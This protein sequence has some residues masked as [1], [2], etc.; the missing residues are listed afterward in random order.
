MT[1]SATTH[2]I[3]AFS[4]F[5][6]CKKRADKVQLFGKESLDEEGNVIPFIEQA[7]FITHYLQLPPLRSCRKNQRKL[8]IFTFKVFL[9]K[10]TWFL[11]VLKMEIMSLSITM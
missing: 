10:E 5:D 6:F 9:K 7:A 8:L 11:N 1:I 4:L 3:K 2:K